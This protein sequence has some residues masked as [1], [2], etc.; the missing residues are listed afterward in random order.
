MRSEVED[1]IYCLICGRVVIGIDH[2]H[3]DFCGEPVCAAC[4]SVEPAM[5][6]TEDDERYCLECAEEFGVTA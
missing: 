3:C 4:L 6:Y 1:N 5:V 2:E